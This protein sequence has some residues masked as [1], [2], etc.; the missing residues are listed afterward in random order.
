[1]K[2]GVFDFFPYMPAYVF[3]MGALLTKVARRAGYPGTIAYIPLLS[4]ACDWVETTV[5][6]YACHLYP[7]KLSDLV[8]LSG[9]RACQMKWVSFCL[10]VSLC[11]VLTFRAKKQD[12]KKT[13]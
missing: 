3:L 7:E 11:V 6:M 13:E 12:S 8:I 4:I 10:G 5:Q 1:M 2:T 9:S